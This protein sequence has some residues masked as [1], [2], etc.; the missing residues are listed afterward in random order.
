MFPSR[1]EL[2]REQ[3]ESLRV[4]LFSAIARCS[5]RGPRLVVIQ[6]CRC[7]V[8]FAFATIP[9]VWP[10]TVVSM[11]HSLR[12]ATQTVQVRHIHM[13]RRQRQR[14]TPMQDSFL[15]K[16][17]PGWNL[18]PRHH[19]NVVHVASPSKLLICLHNF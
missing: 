5:G 8:A 4:E 1:S 13:T 3:Y 11:V 14:Y 17:C 6:L 16:N 15:L 10:N 19:V 12:T 18:N 9:D 2:P 7:L